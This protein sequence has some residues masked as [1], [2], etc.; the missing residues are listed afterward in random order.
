[1]YENIIANVEPFL[2]TIGYKKENIQFVPISGL[3]GENLTEK[4][5][6]T[7]LTSW[8]TG[9]CLA[10]LICNNTKLSVDRFVEAVEEGDT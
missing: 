9:P 2:L 4:S 1:M 7:N 10:D 6:I 3:Q 5:K 8:Y